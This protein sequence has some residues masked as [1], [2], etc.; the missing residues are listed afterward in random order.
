MRPTHV[1]TLLR[2]FAPLQLSNQQPNMRRTLPP[3]SPTAN[4]SFARWEGA[5]VG[6]KTN[7]LPHYMFKPSQ[8]GTGPSVASLLRLGPRAAN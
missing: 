7:T 5:A 2:P 8:Q 4:Y 3:V 1:G 6:A